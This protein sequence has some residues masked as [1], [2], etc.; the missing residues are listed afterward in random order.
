MVPGTGTIPH[1]CDP[2]Y[3]DAIAAQICP[4]CQK[5]IGHCC[6]I[7]IYHPQSSAVHIR[8]AEDAEAAVIA[9]RSNAF[10]IDAAARCAGITQ[11]QFRELPVW[12]KDR[13]IDEAKESP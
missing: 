9:R 2:L 7:Y 3:W 12:D 13:L 10:L 4:H 11:T 6:G 1:G 5:P 8:C